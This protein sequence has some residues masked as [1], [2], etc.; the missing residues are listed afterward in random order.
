MSF[1]LA[2][3]DGNLSI[4]SDG[5]VRTVTDTLKLRQDILKIIV[6]PLGSNKFH[7]W[8]GCSMGE[9][10]IGNNFADNI[11]ELEVQTSVQQSLERLRQLQLAQST[12]QNVSLGE[13]IAAIG[14]VEVNRNPIDLRQLNARV[15]VSSRRLTRIEEI[16]QI[17]A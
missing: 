1:D 6:T 16:F 11:I 10:L 17:T 13:L 4:K 9:G 2:L 3:V 5:S 15:V 7:P 12:S 8:Y 14:E